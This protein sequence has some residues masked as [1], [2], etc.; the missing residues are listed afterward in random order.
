MKVGEQ[1][2]LKE[3]LFDILSKTHN[4]KDIF[5]FGS[6]A[7]GKPDVDNDYDIEIIVKN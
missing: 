1:V 7:Y 3:K 4:S 5:L 2:K 6:Y